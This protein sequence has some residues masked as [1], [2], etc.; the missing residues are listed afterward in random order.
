MNI[1]EAVERASI[2]IAFEKLELESAVLN[3][4]KWHVTFVH[5]MSTVIDDE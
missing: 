3:D 2:R 5:R 4:G 1:T